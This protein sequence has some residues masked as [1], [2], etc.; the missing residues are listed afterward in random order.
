MI[1]IG[2]IV[3]YIIMMLFPF[4]SYF[5]VYNLDKN[6]LFNIIM[7]GILVDLLYDKLFFSIFLI[8][9][10]LFVRRLMVKDRYSFVKNIILYVIFYN[11]SFFVFG[12]NLMNCIYF[13][14][15][16]LLMYIVY[17]LLLRCINN[18]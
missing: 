4:N 8:L 10:Y 2:F 9:L 17:I 6:R 14:I 16:G 12:F 15:Y 5:I 11:V 3:D 1:V 7:I 13:F 18:K